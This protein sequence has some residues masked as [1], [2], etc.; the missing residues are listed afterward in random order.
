[1]KTAIVG[2]AAFTSV[3]LLAA[4]AIWNIDASEWSKETRA[5]VALGGAMLACV[6]MGAYQDIKRKST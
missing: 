1:M 5:F 3:Y 2:L 6:S 4:F